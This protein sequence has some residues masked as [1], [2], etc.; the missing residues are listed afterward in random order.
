MLKTNE[1]KHKHQA[2][3][4][5]QAILNTSIITHSCL[6]KL[7]YAAYERMR[8]YKH[9]DNVGRRPVYTSLYCGLVS[10]ITIRDLLYVGSN[11]NLRSQN[12]LD[13]SRS[14]EFKEKWIIAWERM[15]SCRTIIRSEVKERLRYW[16]YSV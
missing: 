1:Y 8:C 16:F 6:T 3:L 10:S 2:S 4:L 14:K 13:T 12:W 11:C 5:G 9:K 7:L 15:W